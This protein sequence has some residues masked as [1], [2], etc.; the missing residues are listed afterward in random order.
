MWSGR[1][2]CEI[3]GGRSRS[4][5]KTC[6]TTDLRIVT[7][8]PGVGSSPVAEPFVDRHDPSVLVRGNDFGARLRQGAIDPWLPEA[9]QQ[10]RV[11]LSAETT[12]ARPCVEVGLLTVYDGVV[13]PWLLPLSMRGTRPTT[14][15]D[16]VL[17]LP[18]IETP[19]VAVPHE[20]GRHHGA[21]SGARGADRSTPSPIAVPDPECDPLQPVNSGWP[22]TCTGAAAPAPERAKVSSA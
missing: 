19:L 3:L 21:G 10:N 4:H 2:G 5:R 18:P 9:D 8:P 6:L 13:G 12:A 1:V 20:L 22:V 7:G 16:D 15:V 11:A 14:T 17:L